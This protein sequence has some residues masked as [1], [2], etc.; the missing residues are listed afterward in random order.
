MEA[1]IAIKS[2]RDA[3]TKEVGSIFAV[4]DIQEIVIFHAEVLYDRHI[5]QIVAEGC[6]DSGRSGKK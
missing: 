4:L 2:T 5:V 3:Q 6:T 1:V